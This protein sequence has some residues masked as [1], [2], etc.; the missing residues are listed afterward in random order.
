MYELRVINKGIKMTRYDDAA[1]DSISIDL[2]GTLNDSDLNYLG[3][4]ELAYIKRMVEEN[5][6]TFGIF[7]ADGEQIG[8]AP[9]LELAR[10]MAIQNDLY[11]LNVH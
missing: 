7:A 6:N 2:N 4:D 10:A 5:E 1:P 11:P 9:D 3:L 8:M